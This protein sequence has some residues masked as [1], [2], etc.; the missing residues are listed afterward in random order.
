[1][2]ST[3]IAPL[4]L[5]TSYLTGSASFGIS[6]TTLISSGGFLPVGTR[7]RPIAYCSVGC[8]WGRARILRAIR[9]ETENGGPGAAVSGSRRGGRARLQ[10]RHQ[11]QGHD[12]DDLDQ[13]VDRRAGGVLVGIAY[14]VAGDRC[15]VG[16]GT[17]A[18]V[19][20]VLDVLLGVVP[21][22]AAG[23]HRDGHEQSGDDG[24][25]QQSAER[26]RPEQQADD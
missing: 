1:M 7:S 26:L 11:Q 8:S 24:A 3:K 16:L 5:S 12:V 18:A 2:R 9:P 4:S 15:L 22:A 6:M 25:D 19:V 10:Q 20:A 21:G 14:G 23:G 13:R 17:L